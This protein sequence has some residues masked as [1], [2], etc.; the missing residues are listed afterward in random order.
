MPP[1][2]IS[3]ILTNVPGAFGTNVSFDKI[4]KV[5]MELRKAYRD[6]G[7][8][9]VYVGLPQ[10]RL[11]NGTVK[12]QVVEGR[13]SAIMVKGNHYYSSNNIMRAVPGLTTNMI[14]NA[15]TFQAEVNRANANQDRQ[16]SGVIEPGPDPG[17]SDL[18]LQVKDRLP[19]HAKI[20]LNNDSSPGTPDLRVN[21]SAVYDNLWQLDQALG[22]Q[23]S[24]SPELY[25][26]GSQ[27]QFYDLPSVANYSTFYRIPLGNPEAIDNE[28][29]AQPGSFGYDEATRKFNLLPVPASRT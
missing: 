11:T 18:I 23:Y 7:F 29:A 17:T 26:Q 3:M 6:R 12:V 27:W 16:I 9:T 8:T 28:I 25:K 10:Q 24:F 13:L 2:T 20:E 5:V 21:S 4:Q 19:V 14:L 15:T 1:P 22:V